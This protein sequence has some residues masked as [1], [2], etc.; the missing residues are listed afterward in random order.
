MA[1][2][3]KSEK[4]TFNKES[5]S[6]IKKLS[7]KRVLIVDD[8]EEN[9][10]LMLEI[11]SEYKRSVADNGEKAIQIANSNRP[12]DIILLDVMMPGM[13]GYEVCKRLK[14]SE[15]TKHIPIIFLTGKVDEE[16]ESKGIELGAADYIRKPV[17]PENVQQIVK[18]FLFPKFS[19]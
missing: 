13:N 12:P 2:N 5:E 10:D 17:C 18:T 15:Q 7:K 14:A 6:R 1:E 19:E 11:L 8:A 16:D 3:N 4:T 9:L